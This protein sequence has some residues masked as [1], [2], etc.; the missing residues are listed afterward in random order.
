MT[1]QT[2]NRTTRGLTITTEGDLPH[3]YFTL[4]DGTRVHAPVLVDGP[5]RGAS[6]AWPRPRRDD[7]GQLQYVLPN[8]DIEP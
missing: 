3:K 5:L 2:R 6:Q 1:T 7:A 8:G 4:A